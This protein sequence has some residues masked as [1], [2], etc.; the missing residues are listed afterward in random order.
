MK[1]FYEI[2]VWQEAK[3]LVIMVYDLAKKF[4]K[5]ETYSLADQL[6]RAA[7]SICANIAEGVERY[8]TK[9]KVR[10]Y[11]NAR[12]S[13][14]E[15][16]SHLH[17]SKELGYIKADKVTFLLKELDRIGIKLNNMISSLYRCA[18]KRNSKPPSPPAPSS[19]G[20]LVP[21]V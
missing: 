20:L 5:H 13:I 4:P 10:F 2:E 14:S 21:C 17:I 3:K 8:H 6:R 12:G 19:L 11:Y 16:K 15:G 9:D 18:A 7:N 1:E